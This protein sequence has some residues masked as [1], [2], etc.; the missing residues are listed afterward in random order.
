[1]STER[2]L[3]NI[4][5]ADAQ[6]TATV[7]VK[8]REFPYDE[9]AAYERERRE[10]C[11]AFADADSGVLVYRRMRVGECF[12]AGCADVGRSLALQLGALRAGMSYAGDVP[13]F[14]EPW[15]GIG[16]VAGA[17][18]AS[19]EWAPGQ[20]PAVRPMFQSVQEALDA[21]FCAVRDAE[22]GRRTLEMIDWFLAE[23][24]GRVPMSLTDTQSP[25]NIAG[26][27]VDVSSLLLEGVDAPERVR[28]LWRPG[29]KLIVVT[30][31]E[32]QAEQAEAYE[33]VREIAG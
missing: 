32:T 22:I 26:Q 28:R 31:C 24:G 10:R 11:R 15:Y 3:F 13:N 18:G 5:R 8:P 7:P 33:R 2:G 19:Y 21:P 12:S 30:Y 23:T 9:H 20:A 4:K 6:A 1:M 27:V 25:L 14:L 16:T 29:M 17:F